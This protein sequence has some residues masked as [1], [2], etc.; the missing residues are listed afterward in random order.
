MLFL[1]GC[2]GWRHSRQ[3]QDE[4]LE[5]LEA[6]LGADDVNLATLRDSW[7]VYW[8]AGWPQG[9]QELRDHAQVRVT[10][11]F[12]GPTINYNQLAA[13]TIQQTTNYKDCKTRRTTM[14]HRLQYCK[15]TR[16]QVLPSC[17]LVSPSSQ[18]GGPEGAGG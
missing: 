11:W 13:T 2:E 12:P 4:L 14:L 10:V 8:L 3:L 5:T 18:P 6:G 9:P 7:M 17:N 1:K 16:L 15:L